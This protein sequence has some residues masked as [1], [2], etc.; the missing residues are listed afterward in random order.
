M[1]QSKVP[2]YDVDVSSYLLVCLSS[3]SQNPWPKQAGREGGRGWCDSDFERWNLS[4]VSCNW[5]NSWETVSEAIFS[6]KIVPHESSVNIFKFLRLRSS[7]SI[8]VIHTKFEEKLPIKFSVQTL[9]TFWVEYFQLS[10]F[11][12]FIWHA[13]TSTKFRWLI[14]SP[15]APQEKK[16][17]KLFNILC[18]VVCTCQLDSFPWVNVNCKKT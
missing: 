11:S 15:F 18:W 7:I 8:L 17:R 6:P 10:F 1:S 14:R 9:E 3:Q 2:T 16:F 4:L 5:Q 12:V 13:N